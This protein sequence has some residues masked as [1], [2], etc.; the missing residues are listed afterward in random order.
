MEQNSKKGD[1]LN[2]NLP[3]IILPK[4]VSNWLDK[5]N[6][7]EFEKEEMA[8][9]F[10]ILLSEG[11]NGKEG[12]IITH[13]Y[14]VNDLNRSFANVNTNASGVRDKLQLINNG[15][16]IVSKALGLQGQTVGT[17]H[18][19]PPALNT[20]PSSDDTDTY[21]RSAKVSELG[22]W[23]GPI[24]CS[25]TK[26]KYTRWFIFIESMNRL[27]E[28]P[29]GNILEIEDDE[30]YQLHNG[31][32]TFMHINPDYFLS[33]MCIDNIKID[34]EIKDNTQSSKI[35]R[36][37]AA[38]KPA[39]VYTG[40]PSIDSNSP[41]KIEIDHFASAVSFLKR[42][43]WHNIMSVSALLISIMTLFFF[44]KIMMLF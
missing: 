26:R 22:F 15:L 42:V 41:K 32:E 38:W 43:N 4:S 39:H 44:L 40:I 6:C 27:I 17:W 24:A 23:L 9:L 8:H 35:S 19:H 16:T 12:L 34:M 33:A 28:L 37:P 29:E 18:S 25:Y 31:I 2:I 5:K 10:G 14:N 30:I 20:G 13:A 3:I 11:L 1:K 7:I 21:R 36:M